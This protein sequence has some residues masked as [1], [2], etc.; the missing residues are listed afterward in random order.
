MRKKIQL[1]MN[2]IEVFITA[3]AHFDFTLI[4]LNCPRH[5]KFYSYMDKP[6]FKNS[7]LPKT[8]RR[9]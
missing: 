2:F 7:A 3:N 9:Y 6:R 5:V 1:N 8:I 4:K